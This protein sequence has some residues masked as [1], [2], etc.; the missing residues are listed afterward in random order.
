MSGGR[1]EPDL[2][3]FRL[4]SLP[5]ICYDDGDDDDDDGD[6]DGDDG[7]GDDDDDDDDGDGDDGDGLTLAYFPEIYPAV[8]KEG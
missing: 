8:T 1:R 4:F 6:D 2:N 7:D 5:A 3:F